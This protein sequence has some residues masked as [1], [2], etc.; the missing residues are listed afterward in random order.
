MASCSKALLVLLG[1]ALVSS[2][3]AKVYFEEKFDGEL[4]YCIFW[5]FKLKL[6]KPVKIVAFGRRL[7]S[8]INVAVF[9]TMRGLFN[10]QTCPAS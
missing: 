8:M 1:L 10:L 6:L 9:H 7:H 5:S 2:T 4:S 3:F